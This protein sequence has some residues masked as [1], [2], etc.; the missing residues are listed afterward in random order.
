M[1]HSEAGGTAIVSGGPAEK[2]GLKLGDIITKINDQVV[3]ESS[4]LSSIV[5]E[6]LPGEVVKLTVVRDGKTQ[7]IDLTL[8][9][10]PSQS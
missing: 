3:G 6:F 2:A 8:G 10:F 4:S 1:I 7:T 5:S 9:T